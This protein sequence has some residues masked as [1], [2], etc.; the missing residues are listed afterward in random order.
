MKKTCIFELD[1]PYRE[2]MRIQSF[3]FGEQT[4][5]AR[6]AGCAIMGATRGNEAQQI[7]TCAHIVE[8]LRE[9]EQQG[10]IAPGRQ[11]SV[12]PTANPYSV[13]TARRFWPMDDTDINRMFPGYSLGETTQRIAHQVF[14]AVRPYQ[15]GIQFA[16]YYMPGEFMPH[17]RMMRTGYEDTAAAALFGLP[18]LYVRE[19]RP[20]DT[21]TLNYNWQIFETSAFSI[22]AGK[23]DELDEA[24]TALSVRA[25]LHFLKGVGILTA[26]TQIPSVPERPPIRIITNRDLTFVQAKTGGLMRRIRHAG[27]MV[28]CGDELGF[29]HDPYDNSIRQTLLSPR[30]GR[31]FF[32]HRNPFVYE[33]TIAYRILHV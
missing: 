2:P 20:F 10:C 5:S 19:T 29:I 17:I 16:S 27:D 18:Y 7:F 33:N 11:I 13:N 32:V 30:D 9:L 8:K 22:F 4:D 26:Q 23:T 15:Y 6:Q 3:L 31:V 28:K 12:I 21:T 25:T 1:A 14:E 24:A